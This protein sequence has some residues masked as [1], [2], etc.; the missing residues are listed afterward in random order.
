MGRTG[1]ER[2]GSERV[3]AIVF[4]FDGLLMDTE[5]LSLRSWEA[6][7]RR[8]GLTLDPTG[9]FPPHGGGMRRERLARLAAA[10]GP[11]FDPEASHARRLAH[12]DAML[13]DL[14]LMPGM[15]EWLDEAH[16]TGI[17]VAAASSS[18]VEWVTGNLERV[19]VR[20]RFEVVAG[21]D[22][23]D[24]PKPS[25]QVYLLALERLGL[26]ASAC[27]AVEDSPHGID[28]AHAAG[29]ACI[30]IPND[31]VEPDRVAH[32][33]VVLASAVGPRLSRVAAEALARWRRPAPPW[34]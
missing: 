10:V 21:G 1:A 26:P 3:S 31:H 34:R 20:D 19:G 14:P 25:P 12:R 11:G 29:L 15:R 30:T 6:E 32:A 18:S 4:D 17:R 5:T 7:W 9:F 8:W 33:E 16:E 27:V 23:V 28:A 22:E 24:A 2:V 13:A